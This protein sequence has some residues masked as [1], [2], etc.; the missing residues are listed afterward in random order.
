MI[1][2]FL[3][4]FG[5]YAA[6]QGETWRLKNPELM[7]AYQAACEHFNRQYRI[8]PLTMKRVF[9][10]NGVVN[11]YDLQR[12][13]DC[14]EDALKRLAKFAS[15]AETYGA[16]QGYTLAVEHVGK[17]M[18]EKWRANLG[19]PWFSEE[20][21]L[22]IINSVTWESRDGRVLS[23]ED[24]LALRSKKETSFDR[25]VYNLGVEEAAQKVDAVWRRR[26]GVMNCTELCAEIRSLLKTEN[27]VPEFVEVVPVPDKIKEEAE[28]EALLEE[29]LPAPE[30]WPAQTPPHPDS[31]DWHYVDC[32]R[33]VE[34]GHRLVGWFP[35]KFLAQRHC[36]SWPSSTRDY[37]VVKPRSV[38]PQGTELHFPQQ[39]VSDVLRETNEFLA[40]CGIAKVELG[41][42]YFP[43][44]PVSPMV[45]DLQALPGLGWKFALGDRLRKRSGSW[46][47]GKVVGFYSTTQTPRGY[48]VQLQTRDDNGPVQI[49][50]ESALE[51]D[52]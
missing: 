50:P 51:L 1:D 3:K 28:K 8:G 29:L 40:T 2:E 30:P 33:N 9:E 14:V 47:E 6:H 42:E 20:Q 4:R 10:E 43:T 12:V 52:T 15:N 35:T 18:S 46:W 25:G 49:Y 26:R 36:Q 44:P 13:L 7:D 19:K 37:M 31:L 34:H 38:A 39:A 17:K 41:G 21:L 5:D 11:M 16:A 32:H 27:D 24:L 22:E 45:P 48:A 23:N